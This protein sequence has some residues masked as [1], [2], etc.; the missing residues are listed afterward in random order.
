M[1]PLMIKHY[2]PLFGSIGNRKRKFWLEVCEDGLCSMPEMF[3]HKFFHE[4]HDVV[5]RNLL[6]HMECFASQ[7]SEAQNMHDLV[8]IRISNSMHRRVTAHGGNSAAHLVG[9]IVGFIVALM[10]CLHV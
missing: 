10:S 8:A 3:V 9:K 4:R 6:R 1:R 5:A 2:Y 7:N